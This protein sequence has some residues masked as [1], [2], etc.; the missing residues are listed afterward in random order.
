MAALSS[1]PVG[2]IVGHV[3]DGNFHCLL[4]VDPEDADEIHRVEVFAHQLGR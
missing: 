4:L 3:G 1:G 2:A